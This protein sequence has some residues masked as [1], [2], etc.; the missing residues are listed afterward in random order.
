MTVA[1]APTIHATDQ[2]LV[3]SGASWEQFELIRSG[4]ADS[5]GIR[6]SYYKGELEILAVSVEH[7]IFKSIIGHLVETYLIHRGI[8]FAPTGSMTQEIKEVASAQADESY[9]LGEEKVNAARS[10]TQPTPDLSIEIVF[11]SGGPDKLVRYRALGVPEVWFW[12]KGV[13]ALYHLRP[14]GYEKIERSEVL[15]DLEIELLGRCVSTGSMTE[16]F[17]EFWQALVE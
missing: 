8:P 2:Q 17:R 6:L 16:A 5:P 13:F 4:F 11:T 1:L 14:D 15:P 10:G 12:E 7:E 3:H 9:C